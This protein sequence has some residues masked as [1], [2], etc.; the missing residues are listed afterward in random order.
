MKERR[1][2]ERE[3]QPGK[4]PYQKDTIFRLFDTPRI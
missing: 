2:R 4:F 3:V 1:E